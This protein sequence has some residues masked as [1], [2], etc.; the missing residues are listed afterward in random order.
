MEDRAM[1][2]IHLMALDPLAETL[3]D[4]NSC[5]FRLKRSLHLKPF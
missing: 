3:A 4:K 5:R 1:Q 2:A